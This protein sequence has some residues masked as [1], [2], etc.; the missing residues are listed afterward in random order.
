MISSKRDSYSIPLKTQEHCKID[1]EKIVR[2]R[3]LIWLSTLRELAPKPEDLNSIL[4]F[5]AVEV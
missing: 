1:G 2:A 4:R 5:Y 3:L